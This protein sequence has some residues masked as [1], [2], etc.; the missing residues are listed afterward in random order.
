MTFLYSRVHTPRAP[1]P[2]GVHDCGAVRHLLTVV[3]RGTKQ[4]KI[5]RGSRMGWDGM[6]EICRRSSGSTNRRHR[7]A[8]SLGSATHYFGVLSTSRRRSVPYGLGGREPWREREGRHC[9]FFILSVYYLSPYLDSCCV[10][11]VLLLPTPST[12]LS[13]SHKANAPPCP[14]Q[15]VANSIRFLFEISSA[16]YQQSQPKPCY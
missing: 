3:K 13:P 4:K 15:Q 1:C 8:L 2:R 5:K 10:S 6:G 11:I 16:R 14:P 7:G 9:T 12:L